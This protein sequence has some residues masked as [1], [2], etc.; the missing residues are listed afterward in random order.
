VKERKEKRLFRPVDRISFEQTLEFYI[1]IV[2]QI[3]SRAPMTVSGHRLTKIDFKICVDT[4]LKTLDKGL[5][6]HWNQLVAGQEIGVGSKN[7][8]IAKLGK[9]FMRPEYSLWPRARFFCPADA[10]K[11]SQARKRS[12]LV[13]PQ[14]AGALGDIIA[15]LD[16]NAGLRTRRYRPEGAPPIR[17]YVIPPKVE[18]S[19][20]PAPVAPQPERI[21]L[22]TIDLS[23]FQRQELEA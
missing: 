15:S 20:E 2:D 23:G 11:D 4:A 12:Q 17:E 13:L 21:D 19:P 18:S 16:V 10:Y 14:K 1:E 5:L 8:L 9:M 3:E 6:R 7:K 22:S